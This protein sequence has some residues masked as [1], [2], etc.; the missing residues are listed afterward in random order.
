MNG[1]PARFESAG[2]SYILFLTLNFKCM[3]DSFIKKPG[4]SRTPA[5]KNL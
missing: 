4:C 3:E 1:L 2:Q 5:F